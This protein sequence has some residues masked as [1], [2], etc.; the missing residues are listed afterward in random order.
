[1]GIYE[2]ENGFDMCFSNDGMWGRGNYFAVN[3]SYSTNYCYSSGSTK[4]MMVAEV[5]VGQY[6]ERPSDGNIKK[7][8]I[9][10]LSEQS[11]KMK[12]E[13]Y[14]SIKGHTG[15]SDVFIVYD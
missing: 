13:R 6:E 8:N 7:P 12:N 5:L 11:G 4:Q 15:G 2:G 3:A 9:K 14:S 1:M 10:P